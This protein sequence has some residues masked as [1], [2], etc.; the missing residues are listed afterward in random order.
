MGS[1]AQWVRCDCGKE[2]SVTHRIPAM[3]KL[4]AM[5]SCRRCQAEFNRSHNLCPE[6]VP[7]D[8]GVAAC[9]LEWSHTGRCEPTIVAYEFAPS[10]SPDAP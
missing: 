7:L 3:R 2:R 10:V 9:R 6:A 1:E 4:L 5:S 8:G